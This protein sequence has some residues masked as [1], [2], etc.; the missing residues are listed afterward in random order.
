MFRLAT[1]AFVAI[2]TLS[3][4]S[5]Q[6][7]LFDSHGRVDV[8]AIR[9]HTMA[10]MP[11]PSGIDDAAGLMHT[12]DHLALNPVQK[13]GLRLM[14]VP[15]LLANCHKLLAD[16]A[17]LLVVDVA[18]RSPAHQAGIRSGMVLL[19]IDDQDLRRLDDVPPL[20]DGCQIRLLTE[21]GLQS[22]NIN[23]STN[24][25]PINFDSVSVS[26]I[27]GQ[28]RIRATLETQ[29]GSQQIDMQ[30]N[31]DEIDRQIDEL[32]TKIGEQLRRQVGY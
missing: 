20:S 29:S 5:A 9:R 17:G 13:W 32:P 16:G 18:D 8:D 30:G 2:T 27:N 15:N 4:C 31:R 7:S 25:S 6:Q 3:T 10:T 1:F 26:N 21:K 28:I 14:P 12:F 23:L 24:A 22:A 11:I 19:S